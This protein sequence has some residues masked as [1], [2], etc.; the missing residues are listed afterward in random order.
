MAPS[1]KWS[2]GVTAFL[3]I[4]GCADRIRAAE[5]PKDI[6]AIV[7]DIRTIQELF[8]FKP[9]DQYVK[10]AH[11]GSKK[12]VLAFSDSVIVN[13]ALHSTMTK[14]QGTFD[15][16]MSELAGMALAQGRCAIF[17]LFLRGGVDIG[18]WY[19]N[20]T[21]LASESLVGAY[22]AE[23]SAQV[24]VIALTD[25]LYRFLSEHS[26]RKFYSKDV[27]PVR[28]LLRKYR[29]KGSTGTICFWYLDYISVVAEIPWL[30]HVTGAAPGMLGCGT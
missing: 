27:E 20:G 4:L 12:T 16:I 26:H 8:E 30:G 18:W 10:E 5:T 11:A 9:K 24:P 25:K 17:G 14:L 7:T 22:R 6:G 15:P 29:H 21:I 19:R 13:V 1:K 23:N 2:V 3:D 28:T